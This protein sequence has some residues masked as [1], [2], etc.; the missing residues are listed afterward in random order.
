MYAGKK[1]NILVGILFLLFFGYQLFQYSL[2]F[3]YHD[4]W[5]YI[6]LKYVV[7]VG[8]TGFDYG[9]RDIIDYLTS[10]YL[11]WG[12]RVA[13]AFLLIMIFYYGG[14]TG[15]RI[16]Q[17][18]MMT[19]LVAVVYALVK[20]R[21][22]PSPAMAFLAVA[23]WGM[24]EI[25]LLCESAYWMIASFTYMWPIII[26][27]F[28]VYIQNYVRKKTRQGA[29]TVQNIFCFLLFLLA[30]LS[31][32]QVT[33]M[34]IVYCAVT[35]IIHRK[36]DW[37]KNGLCLSGALLGGIFIIIAPGNFA[38]LGTTSFES[39]TLVEKL[40]YSIPRIIKVNFGPESILFVLVL[41]ITVIA[42][43]YMMWQGKR[44]GRWILV[45]SCISLCY[46]ILGI[47]DLYLALFPP[48]GIRALAVVWTL[49]MI[50][51]WLYYCLVMKEYFFLSLLAGVA[52]SQAMLSLLTSVG[53]RSSAITKLLFMVI[54]LTVLQQFAAIIRENRERGKVVCLKLVYA[55]VVLCLFSNMIS[56]SWG[57]Y[58]NAKINKY[59]HEIL[60]AAGERIRTGE[61]IET[62]TMS[63]LYDDRYAQ[64]MPYDREVIETWIQEYYG[65]PK[66]V[67]FV[68]EVP[69]T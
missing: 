40:S 15:I 55:I 2:V 28:G 50:L 33:V 65:L 14:M 26:F 57:Y 43:S 47:I 42:G 48:I 22:E 61:T 37:I 39:T 64:S 6:T 44:T 10:H 21:G 58:Q 62:L 53:N 66:T 45:P 29:K 49:Y 38:R 19:L 13:P 32:E 5:G 4:D 30:S 1:A 25:S 56:I 23:L 24:L 60:T 35:V 8:T 20:K 59:N 68:Y 51:W 3:M 17:A 69:I 31:Q 9:I 63:K 27:L 52:A 7:N 34:A 67:K 18:L 36:K 12:G 11:H 16:A 41:S 46:P 54:I